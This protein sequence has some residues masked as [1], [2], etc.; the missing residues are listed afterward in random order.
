MVKKKVKK[1][2][3]LETAKKTSEKTKTKKSK[4]KQK[5]NKENDISDAEIGIVVIDEDLKVDKNLELEE[6]K[7]YL[8]E[9]KSQ[10]ASD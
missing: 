9:A 1:M 7:A 3:K 8:E 4:T 10:E 2:P 5:K 6:R